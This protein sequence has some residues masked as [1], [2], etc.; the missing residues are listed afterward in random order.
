MNDQFKTYIN[1]LKTN[2]L[3]VYKNVK[4]D[5]YIFFE[6]EMGQLGYC[7]FDQYQGFK[8]STVHKPN[9]NSGTGYGLANT[10]EPTLQHA[11]N[12]FVIAPH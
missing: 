7:Q 11:L 2:G 9:K 8:F 12:C 6:N 10:F 4:R 1:Q 3:R 5:T